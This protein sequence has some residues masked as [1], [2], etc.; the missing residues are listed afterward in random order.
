MTVCVVDF[1][2]GRVGD[3]GSRLLDEDSL[4]KNLAEADQL[5]L[6]FGLRPSQKD[7]QV[8]TPARRAVKPVRGAPRPEPGSPRVAVR[9]SRWICRARC[10]IDRSSRQWVLSVH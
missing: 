6:E 4:A 10:P 5:W 2:Q 9:A 7:S 8:Q 1:L 3:S